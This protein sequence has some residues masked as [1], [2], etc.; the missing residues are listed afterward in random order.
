MSP[1]PKEITSLR[2]ALSFSP[3]N[4]ALRRLLAETLMKFGRYQSAEA[5]WRECLRFEPGS[6]EF[7]VRL[8]QCYVE[9]DRR[10]E[11]FV[12]LEAL[13]ENR[14]L[15]GEGSLTYA[16]LLAQTTE[17]VKAAEIYRRVLDDYP[18]LAD[19]ALSAELE[20]FLV[21]DS[22]GERLPAGDVPTGAQAERERPRITFED[23]G[24]MEE[25]KEQ[26]RMKIIHPI[27]HAELYAAYGKSIGGGILLYGPPGCGKTLM[28]R[29]TAGEVSASF[30]A[31]G[32]HDVLDMWIGQSEK[33]IHEVFEQARG[34][35]PSVLFFDEVD[36]LGASRSD[37]K[38]SASRHTINQFLS[39][40]D[41]VTES[42]EGVLVLAATNAPWH[43]DSALRR[44]GRFDRII[45]VPPP[46]A[47][48]RAAILRAMLRDK[49]VENIDYE[50]VA[51]KTEGF[52]GADLKAV[53]EQ[54]I[55]SKLELA[56]KQGGLV[57]VVTKDLLDMVKRVKP[58]TKEWFST[59]KN[60]ALFSNQGGL[61][62]DILEYLNIKK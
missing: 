31:I 24:G 60:Y 25:V 46:D 21:E 43:L 18:D 20:P 44:P 6:S 45:F 13:E 53:V 38:Q 4:T 22:P 29:A 36:A 35:T 40:L 51:K 54:A 62:D 39:E 7:Q 48:A 14:T 32:L 56:M 8:A 10:S 42:N 59:A 26:V 2:E 3:E 34:D 41:G 61:Y 58:S 16:R 28:A 5:E 12:I 1:E 33:N 9:L 17:L 50:T 49:P 27:Q 47:P 15:G 37:M 55:E 57:P 52:S 19:D 23:V 30:F 11:A